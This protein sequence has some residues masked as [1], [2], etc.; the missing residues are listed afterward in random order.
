MGDVGVGVEVGPCGVVGV[1]VAV[2]VG[3]TVGVTVIVTVGVGVGVAVGVGVGV[4]VGGASQP[5][6]LNSIPPEMLPKLGH[7]PLPQ[8]I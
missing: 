8:S 5:P 6:Q 2:G 4:F 7:A 3:V 1:G